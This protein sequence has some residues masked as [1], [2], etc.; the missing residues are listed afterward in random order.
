MHLIL[1]Q[2]CMYTL[3]VPISVVKSKPAEQCILFCLN[4]FMLQTST[5]YFCKLKAYMMELKPIIRFNLI[6]YPIQYYLNGKVL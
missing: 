4:D 2:L 5:L 6:V 3:L 1:V